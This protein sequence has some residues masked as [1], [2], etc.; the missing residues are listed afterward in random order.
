MEQQQQQGYALD[1][2]QGRALWHLDTLLVFKALGEETGGQFWAMEGLAD[3]RMAVPLHAHSRD[4]EFWYVLEGEFVF[5]MG[6]ET[7][8]LGP[9]AFVYIPRDVP[10]SYRVRSE[11]S[12]WLGIGVPG[13]LDQCYFETGEPARELALPPPSPAPPDVGALIASLQAYG[14]ET[15]GPPPG[16]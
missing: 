2:Q 16:L 12:R 4:D 9:G 5:T 14:T 7:R 11:T 1:V 6:D 10:H 13:G 8:T 3:R 15:L